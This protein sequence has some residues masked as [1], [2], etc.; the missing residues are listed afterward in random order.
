MAFVED[1]SVFFD[2]SDFAESAVIT[3]SGGATRTVSAIFNTPSLSVEI[4]DQQI[5]TDAPSALCKTVD[6]TG[7]KNNNSMAI[8]GKTYKI[9]KIS[10]DGTGVSTVYLK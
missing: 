6:L 5:E 3:L 4:Y 1:L 10:D 9:A 8:G 2:L 7:V